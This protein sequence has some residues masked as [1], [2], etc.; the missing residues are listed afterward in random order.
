M[1]LFNVSPSPFPAFK[2]SQTTLKANG[3]RDSIP[4]T[5]LVATLTNSTSSSSF[6]YTSIKENSRIHSST[7]CLIS[8]QCQNFSNGKVATGLIVFL[9]T[10]GKDVTQPNEIQ[11]K[12]V[13]G[14]WDIKRDLDVAWAYDPMARR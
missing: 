8:R 10:A 6:P 13:G 1:Q 9:S 14:V 11:G 3:E 2:S 4:S 7:L 12:D 5:N